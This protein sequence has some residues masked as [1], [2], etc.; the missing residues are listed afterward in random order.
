MF[1]VLFVGFCI[2]L[3]VFVAL[4]VLSYA[5]ASKT[6]DLY[7]VFEFVSSILLN[8]VY[9]LILLVMRSVAND[10]ARGRSPFTVAHANQIKAI[11]WIFVAGVVLNIFVSPD[12]V[13][14]VRFGEFDLGL[15]SDQLGRY[16]V[17]HIDVKSLVGA[18][19]CFSLS[20]VWKYG[21]L[22]QADSDDYL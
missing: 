17:I 13:E 22:L 12:F 14:L 16:P 8:M 1:L 9:A 21:A 2:S 11:A 6:P 3:V 18:I 20:S 7:A 10:V 19:V 4:K 15:V 5:M